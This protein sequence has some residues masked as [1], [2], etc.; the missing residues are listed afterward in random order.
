VNRLQQRLEA[1]YEGDPN[2]PAGVGQDYLAIINSRRK[3]NKNRLHYVRRAELF[4][5]LCV[6]MTTVE[7]IVSLALKVL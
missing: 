4:G 1:T 3:A 2:A 7:L 6:A 5:V